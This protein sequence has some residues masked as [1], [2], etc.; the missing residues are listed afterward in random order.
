MTKEQLKNKLDVILGTLQ[1]YHNNI[2]AFHW[3]VTA[4]DFISLH[5]YLDELYGATGNH[6]D[7]IAEFNRIYEMHPINTLK[8]Y[9]AKSL[10]S[11]ISP[12]QAED[13]AKGLTKMIADTTVLNKIAKD[14]FDKTDD[15]YP[16]INDYAAIMVADFGKRLWF[17]KAIEK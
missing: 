5:A 16:D 9:L 12:M 2:H 14:C 6:V 13:R 1:V 11:E 4:P 7:A 3:S 15:D 17:L 10:I 8:Q